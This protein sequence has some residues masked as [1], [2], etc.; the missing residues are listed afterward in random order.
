MLVFKFKFFNSTLPGAANPID[1]DMGS[2]LISRWIWWWICWMKRV[3][4]SLNL[5]KDTAC[6]TF[7]SAGRWR[8]LCIIS[9]GKAHQRVMGLIPVWS[10]AITWNQRWHSSLMSLW[11]YQG[12]MS[13]KYLIH[14]GLVMPYGNIDLSQQW[15]GLME[16]IAVDV[17]AFF[18]QCSPRILWDHHKISNG[19][20]ALHFTSTLARTITYMTF[21]LQQ[22]ETYYTHNSV[23]PL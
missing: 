18:S 5:Q 14:Y 22:L 4:S 6:L 13:F 10:Q 17:E 11:C 16:N 3:S 19:F 15:L 8:F 9:T 7:R 1:W 21:V 12:P 20:L 2:T 23:V